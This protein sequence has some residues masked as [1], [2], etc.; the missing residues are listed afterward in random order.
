M[1][2]S[3]PRSTSPV[4][5]ALLASA[6]VGAALLSAPPIGAQLTLTGNYRVFQSD[7][8]GLVEAGD[9]FGQ[10]LAAGDFNGDG[11]D[12]L[13]VGVPGEGVVAIQGAG[14][15][16]ILFGSASGVGKGAL[17]DQGF[18]QD[19]SGVE[20]LAESSD[21][22]G[23]ALAVGDFNGDRY[24]DLAVGVPREDLDGVVN[25][26]AVHIFV[27]SA[28]GL[29]PAPA[30]SFLSGMSF[31]PGV[32]ALERDGR[33]G[34]ALVACDRNGDGKDELV[35][36]IPSALVDPPTRSGAI[37]ELLGYASGVTPSGAVY[38]PSPDNVD[39]DLFGSALACGNLDQTGHD[40]LLVGA[41]RAP[42]PTLDLASAG[43]V[44]RISS[45]GSVQLRARGGGVS[46][47]AGR[48]VAVGDFERD[49]FD[50]GLWGI[51]GRD[52]QS[53]YRSGGANWDGPPAIGQGWNSLGDLPEPNDNFGD[54]VA[55]GDFNRD[56]YVDGVFGIPEED[57]FDGTAQQV[58]DA[59]MVQVIMSNNNGLAGAGQTFHW[60]TDFLFQ[61]L[62]DDQFGAAVAAGDFNKD[63]I[64]DL[65]IGAPGAEWNDAAATGIIQILL[66]SKPNWIFGDGFETGKP[67]KWSTVAP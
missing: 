62:T 36:G 27:G 40:D 1:P 55:A 51:P 58:L 8:G 29:V 49:G 60:G 34:A 32:Y 4:R 47:N 2:T 59:G 9:A 5:R 24:A 35:I 57:L 41:P 53:V 64:D 48:S 22:F 54:L 26:G 3:I 42:H 18:H 56:G 28:A 45:S 37:I 44:W 10:T 50:L 63:G 19:A 38:R 67:W 25:A 61:P 52:S 20:D 43:A 21:Q 14:G 17:A 33:F 6:M 23:G 15:V 13:A 12:D 46:D 7:A 30:N 65:A 11:W 66:G 16:V 39:E 31:G